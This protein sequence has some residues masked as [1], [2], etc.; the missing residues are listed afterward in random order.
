MR[1]IAYYERE[2]ARLNAEI[3]GLTL[4]GDEDEVTIDSLKAE[5]D[6]YQELCGCYE[7]LLACYRLGRR[8]SGK[9]LD[10]TTRLK[11]ALQEE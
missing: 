9:L 3:E 6:K 11:Q 5:R 2:N 4:R 10:D 8:P 1:D 7:Q